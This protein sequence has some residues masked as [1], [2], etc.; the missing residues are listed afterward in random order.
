[1]L[2][3]LSESSQAGTCLP[4]CLYAPLKWYGDVAQSQPLHWCLCAFHL[5]AHFACITPSDICGKNLPPPTNVLGVIVQSQPLHWC[6]C[7]S[8]LPTTLPICLQNL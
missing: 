3:V 7:A 2:L 1:M 4:L 6:L 5:V 8:H